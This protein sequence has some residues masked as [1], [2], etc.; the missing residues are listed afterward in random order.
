MRV[1]TVACFRINRSSRLQ[2][3]QKPVFL[4][5]A[6]LDADQLTDDEYRGTLKS[7]L[8]GFIRL[9]VRYLLPF[10]SRKMTRQ[11]TITLLSISSFP[12]NLLVVFYAFNDDE[13]PSL[14][15]L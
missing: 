12:H 14:K 10:F 5:G 15:T 9:D 6:T 8:K 13:Q 3:Y 7:R 4:Q 2:G 1:V 11:V